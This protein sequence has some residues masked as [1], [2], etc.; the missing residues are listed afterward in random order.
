M[1]ITNDFAFTKIN[2][3]EVEIIIFHE[4]H[5]YC[6]PNSK[7]KTIYNPSFPIKTLF[8][9]N[10]HTILPQRVGF[11]ALQDYFLLFPLTLAVSGLGC[12]L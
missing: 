8:P 11:Y 12:A 2:G 7:K 5:V 3:S 1:M 10:T 9:S 4:N 6:I